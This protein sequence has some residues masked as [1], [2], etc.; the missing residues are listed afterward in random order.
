MTAGVALVLSR[1]AQVEAQ[2]SKDTTVIVCCWA[3]VGLALTVLMC[4]FG[5]GSE[6]VGA[7]AT[8]G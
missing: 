1:K 8:A 7:L 4:R 3:V 5:F 6:V 2:V